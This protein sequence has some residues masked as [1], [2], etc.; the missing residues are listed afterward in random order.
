M[1]SQTCL[2]NIDWAIFL[3]N[4]VPAWSTQHCIGYFPHKSFL[5]PMGQQVISLCNFDPERS[6]HHCRLFSSA[7]LFVDWAMIG[8]EM[9]DPLAAGKYFSFFFLSFFLYFFE[10]SRIFF[11]WKQRFWDVLVTYFAQI[12][13]PKYHKV[14]YKYFN[15]FLRN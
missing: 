12:D 7:K 5:F 13:L 11:G 3:C 2:D 14:V 10:F 6:R 1:L 8:G 9:I 4:A 15:T